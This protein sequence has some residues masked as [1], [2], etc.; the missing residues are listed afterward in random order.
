MSQAAVLEGRSPGPKTRK[1]RY[2]RSLF[3]IQ[4]VWPKLSRT[5]VTRSPNGQTTTEASS[6]YGGRLKTDETASV[7]LCLYVDWQG[8]KK[9]QLGCCRVQL[10]LAACHSGRHRD[11]ER[12][13]VPDVVCEGTEEIWDSIPGSAVT[14]PATCELLR[15]GNGDETTSHAAVSQETT[16]WKE[17]PFGP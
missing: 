4:R 13:V 12:V 9:L 6:S 14:K 17:I 7:F 16:P 15:Q 1:V 11:L 5:L 10:C 3:S 8:V 2:G